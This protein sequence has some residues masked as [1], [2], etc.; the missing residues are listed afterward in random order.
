MR[1]RQMI[2]LR[3]GRCSIALPKPFKN[4]ASLGTL[5]CDAAL[6]QGLQLDAQRGFAT[7]ILETRR[8]CTDDELGEIAV[9]PSTPTDHA[10]P[11]VSS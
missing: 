6:S 2:A 4:A 9:L 10:V 5:R 3:L 11:I 8:T 7:A 1:V